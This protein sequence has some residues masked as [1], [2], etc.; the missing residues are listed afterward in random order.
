M[1]R[2]LL[3]AA[4]AAMALYSVAP[5][6]ADARTHGFYRHGHGFGHHGFGP[7]AFGPPGYG[8][9]HGYG[10]HRGYGRYRHGYGGYRGRS[11]VPPPLYRPG[12]PG[13]YPRP[14]RYY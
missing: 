13:F 3:V 1:K 7:R 2:N 9:R 6:E 11:F 12:F 4:L 14:R 10:G 8:F 5:T